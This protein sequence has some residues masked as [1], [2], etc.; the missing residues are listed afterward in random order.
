[1]SHT[2]TAATSN[3]MQNKQDTDIGDTY[4]MLIRP[5]QIDVLVDQFGES[6]VGRVII[7]YYATEY[8]K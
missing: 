7:C 5:H 2:N 6:I 3:S 4:I 1:M 8:F